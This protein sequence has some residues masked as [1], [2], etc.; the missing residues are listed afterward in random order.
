M[1]EISGVVHCA[2]DVFDVSLAAMDEARFRSVLSSRINV[3]VAIA[4]AVRRVPPKDFV[5]FFSSIASFARRGG[6]AG[7]ASGCVFMDALAQAL[8]GEVSC[9]VKTVN[10]GYWD[11]GAGAR[12]SQQVKARQQRAG[13]EAIAPGAAWRPCS[14]S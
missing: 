1:G 10:W 11:I 2:M 5:L 14:R 3:S 12:V 9:A 8:R 7:Y 4:D 13:I 6:Y